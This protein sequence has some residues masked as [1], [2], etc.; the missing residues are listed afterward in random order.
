M[1]RPGMSKGVRSELRQLREQVRF[2]LTGRRCCFCRQLF[3]DGEVQ[4]G[5]ADGAK[6]RLKLALHHVNENRADN[7]EEVNVKVCHRACHKR[8]HARMQ[9]M[10]KRDAKRAA[11]RVELPL[12][13]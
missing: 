12:V 3:V 2:L 6:Y 10:D 11:R 4:Y 8:H 9:A 13:A 7:R 1:R 5:T